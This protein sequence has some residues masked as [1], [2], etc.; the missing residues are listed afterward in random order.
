MKVLQLIP[1]LLLLLPACDSVHHAV[2]DRRHWFTTTEWAMAR[3]AGFRRIAG[4]HW[5]YDG[6]AEREIIGELGCYRITVS[7]WWADSD[8]YPTYRANVFIYPYAGCKVVTGRMHNHL[9]LERAYSGVMLS[10]AINC[11][12]AEIYKAEAL[13]REKGLIRCYHS[14]VMN[15]P[16]LLTAE[17]YRNRWK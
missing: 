10:E 14:K 8:R 15:A 16:E 11:A 2:P 9:E 13:Y 4:E 17:E 1:L 12:L 5:Q 7:K 6:T 3:E